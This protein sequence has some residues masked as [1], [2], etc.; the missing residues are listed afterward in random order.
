MEADDLE[1][2]VLGHHSHLNESLR[3]HRPNIKGLAMR[4]ERERRDLDPRVAEFSDCGKCVGKRSIAERLVANG[5]L[6]S[7]IREP[8]SGRQIACGQ[9]TVLPYWVTHFIFS[10]KLTRRQ[11]EGTRHGGRNRTVY[12]S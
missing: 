9:A 10:S 5:K 6:H 1:A 12:N 11:P 3:R 4:R 8:Q 2:G 7:V